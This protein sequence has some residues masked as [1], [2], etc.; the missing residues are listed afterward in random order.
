[1]G[2]RITIQLE[3]VEGSA[4]LRVTDTGI[5][6]GPEFLPHVFDRFRQEDASRT[7]M[8]G[9]LGLGLAIVRHLVESHGG[10]IHA[11]SSGDEQGSTFV[12]RLPLR[13]F[14][15]AARTAQAGD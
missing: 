1:M 14:S 8:H 12:V 3:E 7:R 2:G 15:E 13:T 10:S 5:G 9:G 6:I 11:L 4:E